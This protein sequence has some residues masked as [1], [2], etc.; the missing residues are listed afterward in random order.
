MLHEGIPLRKRGISFF[1]LACSTLMIVVASSSASAQLRFANI[2][3]D[4]MVL[5][6]E[7]PVQ[8]WDW[9]EPDAQVTVAISEDEKSAVPYLEEEQQTEEDDTYSVTIEYLEQNAPPFHA[10]SRTVEAGSK[11]LWQVEFDKMAGGFT[12]K[13]LVAVSGGRGVAIKNILIGEI[14]VC[15]GQSNMEWDDCMARDLEGPGAVFP[16]I[17]YTK[18]GQTWYKPLE[19]LRLSDRLPTWSRRFGQCLSPFSGRRGSCFTDGIGSRI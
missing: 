2:F 6:R 1:Q 16:G 8:I 9:A 4:N 10:R 7:K 13:F 5:Q 3:S 12:P 11:G 18:I 19:E 14:S 15:S 17:R